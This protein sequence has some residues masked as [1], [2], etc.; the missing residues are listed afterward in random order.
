LL[1]EQAR[2]VSR[3]I[4]VIPMA[5]RT[6]FL[7]DIDGTLLRTGGAGMRA[8][9]RAAVR[10]FGERFSWEGVVVSGHLDPLIF[11]EAVVNNGLSDTLGRHEAFRESYLD[12][13]QAELAADAGAVKACPGVREAIDILRGLAGSAAGPVLGLLT[14]NY[15]QAVPLKL[16]AV[17]LEPAWFPVTAFGD[18]ASSRAD[19]V[20]LAMEKYRVLIGEAIEPRRVVVIGDTPRDMACA[21]AHGCRPF[22]VATGSYS[23]QQLRESGAEVAVSDLTD[24]RPLLKLLD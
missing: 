4:V 17:S 23:V 9:R 7:F 16:R 6:L 8:M 2:A 12:L 19:L 15:A 3:L 21:R 1:F 20:V 11:A 24:P 22:A 14:G 18:E 13:L 5:S 10:L